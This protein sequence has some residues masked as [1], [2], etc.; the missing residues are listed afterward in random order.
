MAGINPAFSRSP[1]A[2]LRMASAKNLTTSTSIGH[3]RPSPSSASESLLQENFRRHRRLLRIPAG[4]L[5]Q[6]TPLGRR[7]AADRG[8]NLV[9][10][11]DLACAQLSGPPYPSIP[12]ADF[13][14]RADIGLDVRASFFSRIGSLGAPSNDADNGGKET[15]DGACDQVRPKAAGP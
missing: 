5:L 10:A 3:F 6:P 7:E 2:M 4:Y 12:Y 14:C 11:P 8:G 9:P 1:S 13:R 15:R